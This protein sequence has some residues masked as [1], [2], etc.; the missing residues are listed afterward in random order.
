MDK[1]NGIALFITLA[2]LASILSIV[3]VSFSYIDKAREDSGAVSAL[4]EANILYANT[5]Q[6][7]NNLIPKGKDNK[8]ILK[9]LY[10]TPI[11]LKDSA[12][13]SLIEIKCQPLVNGV[14]INWLKT[15]YKEENKYKIANEVLD[16][17]LQ[18]V[19]LKEPNRFKEMLFAQIDPALNDGGVKDETSK[20]YGISTQRQMK[21]IIREY[22]LKY[23]DEDI[24][25]IKF[26]KY[27]SFINNEQNSTIDSIFVTPEAI[28]G[29]YDMPMSLAMSW[30]ADGSEVLDDFIALNAPNSTVDRKVFSNMAKNHLRCEENFTYRNK[31]YKF[32]FNYIEGRSSNFEFNH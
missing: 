29:I 25:K 19:R 24:F 23:D 18:R 3:A 31:S 15:R 17:V 26:E 27:F 9:I 6:S 32:K 28:S 7:L 4:I 21:N 16:R 30:R 20:R 12:T 8:D 22:S 5:T 14:P 1:K 10:V 13:S 2:V 11:I